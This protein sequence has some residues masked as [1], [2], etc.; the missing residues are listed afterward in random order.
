MELFIGLVGANAVSAA[1]FALLILLLLY[2]A[3]IFTGYLGSPPVGPL[4]F[5]NDG[6]VPL[7]SILISDLLILFDAGI[8]L[9][10]RFV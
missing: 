5:I 4:E 3:Y 1:I 7:T 8:A 2:I 6:L 9:I 10:L